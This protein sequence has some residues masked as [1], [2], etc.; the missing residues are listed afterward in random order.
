MGTLLPEAH[1]SGHT[2]MLDGKSWLSDSSIR[3]P[4]GEAQ[5]VT[6]ENASPLL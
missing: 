5:L 3:L 1:L 4:D 6:P 2:L